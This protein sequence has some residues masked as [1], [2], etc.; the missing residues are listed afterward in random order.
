LDQINT[1]KITLNSPHESTT[2]KSHATQTE[3]HLSESKQLSVH[4][5]ISPEKRLPSHAFVW[6]P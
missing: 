2:I 5:L 4:K 6:F 3:R 1:I